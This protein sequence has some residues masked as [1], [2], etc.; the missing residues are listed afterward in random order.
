M[1]FSAPLSHGASL[2]T[3]SPNT[4]TTPTQLPLFVV[5]ALNSSSPQNETATK[6]DDQQKPPQPTAK[7][8]PKP[9]K[10]VYSS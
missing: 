6:T 4:R 10:P 9:A 1:A 7:P 2:S 5:R 3:F 8:P